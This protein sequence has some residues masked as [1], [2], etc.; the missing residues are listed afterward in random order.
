VARLRPARSTDNVDTEAEEVLQRVKI[1]RVFDFDGFREAVDEIR[2]NLETPVVLPLK[3]IRKT[4]H[5]RAEVIPDSEDEEEDLMAETEDEVEDIALTVLEPLKVGL[6]LI[7]NLT[8]PINPLMKNNHVHGGS[9]LEPY[10]C[11]T[12]TSSS[13]RYS[14]KV[15]A[16]ANY[17]F[18]E[19]QHHHYSTELCCSDKTRKYIRHETRRAGRPNEYPLAASWA[20]H[21]SPV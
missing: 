15:H 20:R 5:R 10:S 12:L 16:L 19:A 21:L 4:A 3:S 7:D 11:F 6:I 17:S 13:S 2:D 14:T 1:V 18:A 8:T 9:F